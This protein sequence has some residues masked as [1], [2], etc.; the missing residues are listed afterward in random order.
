M[1]NTKDPGTQA[2][3]QT[4]A[5]GVRRLQTPEQSSGVVALVRRHPVGR[6]P[7]LVLHDRA[8][9]R[10]RAARRALVIGGG[11]SNRAVPARRH[12]R[13]SGAAHDG[14]HLDHRRRGGPAGT[15]ATDPGGVG[16]DALVRLCRS[17]PSPGHRG[18]PGSAAHRALQ[19]LVYNRSGSLLPV[20]LVHAAA[21]ATAAGSLAGSGL[22]DRLYPGVGAGGLVFPI[23]G[24]LGLVAIAM[25]RGR[26]GH[27]APAEACEIGHRP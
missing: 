7:G 24:A 18:A 11:P 17:G 14:D 27:H 25:T 3:P 1:R 22:L 10:V 12:L 26:L 2:P 4:F 16:T 20:A 13:R 19:A 9:D 6:V 8:S 15:A 23:L 5:T 21:N